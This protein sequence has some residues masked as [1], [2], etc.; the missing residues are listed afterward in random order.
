MYDRRS[1][2][3][4]AFA[5]VLAAR[6][7]AVSSK[8][9]RGDVRMSTPSTNGSL[10]T[11]KQIDAGSLNVGY[12]EAGPANGPVVLLLHGWPYDIHAYAD[13]TP[14]LTAK[15]YRVIVPY[16]RGYGTTRFLS[17]DTPRNGQQSAVAVDTI[18]LMDALKIQKAIVGGFDWGS[19]NAAIMAALWPERVKALVAVSGYLIVDLKANQKPLPPKAELGWW[20]LYYFTT[21][22]GRLGYEQN[23]YEFNKLIW[24][25]ASP[26]WAFDKATYDRTAASFD[27]P[28]HV[29]IVIHNYRWRLGLAKGESRYDDLEQKLATGPA[30]TVP[31][32]TIS[33]DFDGAAADGAAYAKKFTAKYSHKVLNGI[34]HNVPQEAPREFADAIIEVDSY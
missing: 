26:K 31:A 17:S 22:R 11:L 25:L 1:F 33:S 12:A 34:G 8:T 28:D 19:R 14:L 20:Y 24:Q 10:E 15:G 6:L 23:R 16:L 5:S 2:L 13:V 3:G 21:E 7:G 4:S 18:A 27:N 32:I 30:I 9:N 29:A